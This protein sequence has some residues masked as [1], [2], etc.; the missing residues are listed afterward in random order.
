MIAELKNIHSPDIEE[1]SSWV[2]ESDTFSILLQ[3]IIG[4]AGSPG[5]ESFDITLCTPSWI[6]AVLKSEKVMTGRHL[7]IVSEFNYDRIYNFISKY[8]SSCSGDNWSEVASKLAR[9]GHW[10]FEDYSPQ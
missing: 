2:P 5:E 9:L 8:A 10:E 1:L 4:P 6:E 7:L 3:A